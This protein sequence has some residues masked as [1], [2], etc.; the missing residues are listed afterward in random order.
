[1]KK[2]WLLPIAVFVVIYSLLLLHPYNVDNDT[3]HSMGWDFYAF[4]KLPYIGS[5]DQ[6]FPGIVFIHWLGIAITGNNQIG[7]RLIEIAFQLGSTVLLLKL[8]R[9]WLSNEAAWIAAIGYALTY[10]R[11]PY[12]ELGQR[13]G[14]VTL[15]LLG[16]VVISLRNYD[17][18]RNQ[19]GLLHATTG[20]LI[21]LATVIRPTYSILLAVP[22]LSLFPLV[23]VASERRNWK[24]AGLA[25]AGFPIPITAMFAL[26]LPID[27]GLNEFY[28]ATIR[29]NLDVYSGLQ[30]RIFFGRAAK[31]VAVILA[32]GLTTIWFKRKGALTTTKMSKQ[33]RVYLALMIGV[34]FIEVGVMRKLFTYHFIPLTA[35]LS[36]VFAFM[37][38]KW[39]Q[40]LLPQHGRY[41]FPSAL[42]ILFVALFPFKLVGALVNHEAPLD[43][44]PPEIDR[45][46]VELTRYLRGATVDGDKIEFASICCGPRW[47]HGRESAT[48]F[49]TL[50][51]L[52]LT[53]SGSYTDYQLRMRESYAHQIDEARPKLIVLHY[54]PAK[55]MFWP[56]GSPDTAVRALPGMDSILRSD[57]FV[58]TVIAPYTVYRRIDQ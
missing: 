36:I 46:E 12:N 28:I 30:T 49:T 24:L 53:K 4:G 17:R 51:P 41:F 31:C 57:Y 33:E 38:E 9:R 7:L 14:F 56:I 52:L 11:G 47:R 15:F 45:R 16:A 55:E 37:M 54:I 50:Y 13:D 40:R 29:F 23:G 6:N 22:Y 43:F 27:G 34:G 3:Y 35:A 1:M 20:F 2:S 58:D 32:W 8:A 18:K 48:R 39:W 42:L 10:L 5:W 44:F 21:G 26:Y 19:S 25:V